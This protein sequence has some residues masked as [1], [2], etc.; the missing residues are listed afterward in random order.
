MHRALA[1]IGLPLGSLITNPDTAIWAIVAADTWEWFPFT[2]LMMLAALQMMPNEPLEAARIDGASRLQLFWY[3][4]LALHPA[5]AGRRRPVPADRQH[6][7]LPADLRADRRRA[8]ARA[9]EV[10]NYYAFVQTFNFSYWG[11]GS[12]IATL[13]VAGVFLLSLLIGRLDTG[14]GA[15]E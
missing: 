10:T 3:I 1:A 15:H 5:D 2:M 14:R 13:M 4:V 7:G 6:Q 12:A 11:Y 9:T 8:R